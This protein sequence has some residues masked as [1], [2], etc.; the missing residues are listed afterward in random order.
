MTPVGSLGS[1][2]ARERKGH[3][4]HFLNLYLDTTEKA[5]KLRY[6]CLKFVYCY[7]IVIKDSSL[8]LPG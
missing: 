3:M 1:C 8:L 5:G 4:Q 6:H 2:G 7:P